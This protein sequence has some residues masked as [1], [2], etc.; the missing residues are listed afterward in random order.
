M[1]RNT[2]ESR[3]SMQSLVKRTEIARNLSK[4]EFICLTADAWAVTTE[5]TNTFVAMTAHSIG[6]SSLKVQS[7]LLS[8]R[9][10]QQDLTY[11]KLVEVIYE[12]LG[13]Y[14]IPIEKICCIVTNN[15]SNLLPTRIYQIQH[16]ED[17]ENMS[18]NQDCPSIDNCDN[19][20]NEDLSFYNI[21]SIIANSVT[22]DTTNQLP[23]HY[24]CPTQTLIGVLATS[25]FETLSNPDRPTSYIF[26]S[27]IAKCQ[28]LWKVSLF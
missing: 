22:A 3:I 23:S 16:S 8:C 10:F 5:S 9:R 13:I 7:S 26:Q 15:A 24:D 21:S 2:L 1:S 27:A 6:S 12:V 19:V 11:E 4:T 14:G 20:S 17:E 25:T 28:G 18:T